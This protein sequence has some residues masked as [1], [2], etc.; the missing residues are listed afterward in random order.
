MKEVLLA[1]LVT[2]TILSCNESEHGNKAVSPI[3][4]K[5]M[6]SP[7]SDSCAE[8]F[9]FT[10]K[11]GM[12]YLSWIEKRGKQSTLYF[13]TLSNDK[14]SMPQQIAS[15]NNWFVNWADYPVIA[16][17]G[18]GN[19]LV[20][21]LQK[22]DTAKFTYDVKMVSSNDSGKTWSQS[23]I[24]NEDNVKAEHGFVSI[25]PYKNGFFTAWLDG[26]KTA[27]E[28]D[29]GG[30]GHHG[31]MTL[32]GAM[33]DMSGNKTSEWELDN[34]IC[35]CCQT[36]VAI[37]E[38]GPVV[39]YRDRSDEEVRDMSIVRYVNGQWSAP[40]TIHADNWQIKACPVNGP[41]V[42]GVGNNLAVAWF[43][44]KDKNGEVK[45]IFSKD[46]GETFGKPIRIDDGNTIG[47]VDAVMI[48]S[49]TA[50]VSWMESGNIKAAK[51]HNDGTKENSILIA[52]SSDKRSS[53][54]PQMTKSGNRLIFAW[55][56]DKEKTV[57]V[58][59]IVL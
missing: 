8:P 9:L 24:L 14:W 48:D 12:I 41:R 50:M 56:D 26:R 42:S 11:N 25:V 7:A 37:T 20:H 10:D 34:R 3:Q 47:R 6:S 5:Q 15:G 38:T 46:G 35:D 51:V 43:S 31:E 2:A 49:T 29:D 22:S 33:L 44:I 40:K 39:T 30:H 17:D 45:L 23:K 32:R 27:M 52:S 36:S 1:F 18:A 54:F 4:M 28:G 59:M 57:K 13:S 53:G 19:L 21:F 58:G 55:T 16:S